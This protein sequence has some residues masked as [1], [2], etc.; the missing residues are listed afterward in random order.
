GSEGLRTGVWKGLWG[1]DRAG[2]VRGWSGHPWAEEWSERESE[3]K[4]AR[5]GLAG[6]R[7]EKTP[8]V[9]DGVIENSKGGVRRA[10]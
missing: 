9:T 7:E 10:F 3:K 8:K 5:M 4:R 6:L 1:D 2:G